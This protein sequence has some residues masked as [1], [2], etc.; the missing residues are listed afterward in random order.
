M[1]G[2][3]RSVRTV[4]HV[5]D[6]L[7]DVGLHLAA[8]PRDLRRAV[9]DV[10]GDLFEV[11]LLDRAVEHLVG[12]H[13]HVDAVLAG[14][15]ARIAAHLDLLLLRVARADHRAQPFEQV[16]AA[17]LGAVAALA[18][19]AELGHRRAQWSLTYSKSGGW[20]LAPCAGGAM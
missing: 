16:A 19:V 6:D 2:R 7:L 11:L 14:A 10:R 13:G 20:L 18:D 15:E 5:P 4:E 3:R 17:L 1:Q 8:Q 12:I 9:A